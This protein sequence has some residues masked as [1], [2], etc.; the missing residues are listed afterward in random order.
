[1][2]DLEFDTMSA[3]PGNRDIKM[4]RTSK[5]FGSLLLDKLDTY[6]NEDEITDSINS[7][8]DEIERIEVITGPSKR[9]D[10]MRR[11][12]SFLQDKLSYSRSQGS[13]MTAHYKDSQG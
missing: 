1:M 12:I 7:L 8:H 9:T 13:I 5:Y 10:K 11:E 6:I 4:K 2:L 3:Q